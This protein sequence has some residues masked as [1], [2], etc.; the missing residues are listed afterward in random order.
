MHGYITDLLSW[1]GDI[2]MRRRCR[3]RW[4]RYGSI[5]LRWTCHGMQIE[6]LVGHAIGLL[7][8]KRGILGSTGRVDIIRWCILSF[9]IEYCGSFF[10]VIV[11]LNFLVSAD[12]SFRLIEG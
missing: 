7:K 8:C 6:D 11:I 3:G 4:M 9:G 1:S 2:R 5:S 10:K 12:D